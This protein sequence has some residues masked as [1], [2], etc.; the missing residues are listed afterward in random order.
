MLTLDYSSIKIPYQL[1]YKQ[2]FEKKSF[3]LIK[4][5]I[6][7]STDLILLLEILLMDKFYNE[8][9]INYIYLR[10]LNDFFFANINAIYDEIMQTFLLSFAE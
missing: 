1:S 9:Y 10:C 4:Y 7:P 8:K 2:I 5:W 6:Q 3:W